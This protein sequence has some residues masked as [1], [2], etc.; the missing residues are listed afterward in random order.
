MQVP[1]VGFQPTGSV[2]C[3]AHTTSPTGSRPVRH[4]AGT[5]PRGGQVR[6]CRM[7]LF[8]FGSYAPAPSQETLS[9]LWEPRPDSLRIPVTGSSQHVS[10]PAVSGTCH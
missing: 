1:P 10:H 8:L 7:S 4:Y 3:H 9:T 2:R 6:T 5:R